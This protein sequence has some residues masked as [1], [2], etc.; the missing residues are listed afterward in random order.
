MGRLIVAL[1]LLAFAPARLAA[2]ETLGPVWPGATT[3]FHVNIPAVGGDP[4]WN[5]AF[6]GA[7]ADW[8]AVTPFTFVIVRNSSANPC[9]NPNVTP[10]KNG[11]R[12]ST[13]VCGA[14]WGATTLAVA[15]TWSTSGGATF[16][17]SS[18]IFNSNR[19]WDVYNGPSQ[20]PGFVG[21]FDFR[22]VAGH[23]LGHT[24]GLGHEDDV[25]AI[26]ATFIGDLE[27]PQQDDIDGVNTLYP[28]V[29]ADG[30]AYPF[31]NCPMS[32]N[33]GQKDLDGDGLGNACDMDDDNDG[34]P[35][36]SDSCPKNFS[37][38]QN[39]TDGDGLGNA[40]DI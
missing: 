28:D 39:D 4:N 15:R 23:E 20:K 11:A 35:D 17:Q 36:T 37:P 16:L 7:M 33:P 1:L 29:D 34:V 26:M 9:S 25:P 8:N 14:A 21:I 13:T 19:S 27:V 12:F 5:D 22:R 3:T 32:F 2:F 31:D 30:V 38:K 24:L 6:E 18:I 10:P 40:C